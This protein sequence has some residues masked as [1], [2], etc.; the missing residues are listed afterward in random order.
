MVPTVR[1]FFDDTTFNATHVV[2][3]PQTGV[4]AIIDTVLDF[5]A[6][7]EQTTMVSADNVIDYVTAEGLHTEWILETHVHADHLTAAPYIR[8]KLGG[9]V[10]I[11]DGVRAV[12]DVF[13]GIFEQDPTFKADGSDFDHLFADGETF[14]IGT[15]EARVIHTPGHT[16]ACVAYVIGDAV[17]TGDTLFMPDSGTARCDFPGG[18]AHT[19]YQSI[20]KI[21]SLPPEFRV[22]V[23]HDYAAGGERGY[24]WET[25]IARQRDRNIHV[26]GGNN[27]K[28]FVQMREDR[29]ATLSLPRLIAPAIQVNA[30]AGKLPASPGNGPRFLKKLPGL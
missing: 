15:M 3:D 24:A 19:L 17:F 5:D 22:F 2:S 30:R 10:G 20:S 29:D 12:Q 27:E 9:V 7:T 1:T 6:E 11:G 18:D 4:C 21:L 28:S 8:E 16:P 23:N 13:Q 26:G 14:Q 25:T